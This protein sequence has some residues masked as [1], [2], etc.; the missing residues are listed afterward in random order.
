MS[1]WWKGTETPVSLVIHSSTHT[2]P[3]TH[4]H[5]YF[6]GWKTKLLA[7]ES[8]LRSGLFSEQDLHLSGPV[9]TCMN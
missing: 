2:P 9:I 3:S 7:S 5:I 8:D 6:Q 4:T 1:S